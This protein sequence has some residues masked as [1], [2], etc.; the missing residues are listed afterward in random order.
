MANFFS[1]FVGW[2]YA[3]AT[4]QNRF[5]RFISASS[6]IGIM[7]GCA[8]LI[9]VLSAMNGFERE[10]KNRLL[11]VVS[12]IEFTAVELEGIKDWQS[13][14]AD[15]KNNEQVI[16]VAPFI[17]INGL[18]Q[19]GKHLKPL[20]VRGIDWQL[21]QQV[22]DLSSY[23]DA[24]TQSRFNQGE[25]IILGAGLVEELGLTVGDKVEFLIPK[26]NESLK[27]TAPNLV[28]LELLGSFKLGGQLDYSMG[29]VSLPVAAK[30]S[31]WQ[32]GVQG[33]RL[34]I[35]EVFDAPS[36]ARQIG[37]Q[38]PVYVYIGNW[39]H[40]YGHLYNDILL[41]R[42]VMYIIL[43]LVIAVACFNIVSTLVMAVNEKAGDIAI[44]KTMGTHNSTIIRIFMLQGAYNG[45]LGV[46]FGTILGC[47][48]AL[49][50]T[51]LL[52]SIESLLGVQFLA[53]D[54]YF[55]DFLPSQLV[56]A[57][58]AVTAGAALLL[59]LFST[60][61]PAYRATKVDPAGVLGGQ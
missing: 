24:Q 26:Q 34:K 61:Y 58:V 9:I 44:L 60:I 19:K 4:T 27:L 51:P 47:L 53:A 50:L 29:Y 38:L 39:T 46:V 32:Q 36:I 49:Y 16:A 11:S 54:V 18:L 40:E 5:I 57:D 3:R 1:L 33:L 42:Q 23:V 22:S 21:E 17:K 55:V 14:A 20:Q 31:G 30:E 6:I 8:V 10:L 43:I 7:L 48:G 59:S 25:G 28:R 15:I 2:R 12:H 45:I 37:F 35:N 56:V 13:L 41:V 52:R